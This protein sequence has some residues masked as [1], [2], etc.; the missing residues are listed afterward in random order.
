MP[1]FFIELDAI[2]DGTVSITGPLARHLKGSLR[3]R[4]GE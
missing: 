1:V 3:V 2:R 4:P